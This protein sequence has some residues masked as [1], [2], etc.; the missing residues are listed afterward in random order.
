MLNHPDHSEGKELRDT[1]KSDNYSRT[2]NS[3]SEVHSMFTLDPRIP[4]LALWW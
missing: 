4:G 3:D 2:Y 1:I